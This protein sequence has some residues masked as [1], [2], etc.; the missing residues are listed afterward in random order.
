MPS[1]AN[2]A[3][4]TVVDSARP[5][6]VANRNP[7]IS[8]ALPLMAASS[9]LRHESLR[10]LLHQRKCV[11]VGIGEECHPEVVIVHPRDQVRL[12]GK[13]G[14]ALRELGNRQRDVC[15]AEI[16]AALRLDRLA[17]LD[18][19]EQEPHAGAVEERQ[20]AKAVEFPQ[21]YNFLIEGLGAID[22]ARR[23]RDLTDL[24]E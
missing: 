9:C 8:P 18:L 4:A 14:A 5:H 24:A 23:Q 12:R 21:A 13:C 22:V 15:A 1:C 6:S 7:T 17:A 20:I 10:G 2:A 3:E 19:V 16:D 11:A